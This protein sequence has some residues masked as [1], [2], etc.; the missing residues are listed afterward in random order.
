[1]RGWGMPAKTV[2]RALA[3]SAKKS[4]S[5]KA[6]QGRLRASK[7]QGKKAVGLLLSADFRLS[8]ITRIRPTNARA[9]RSGCKGRHRTIFTGT[10]ASKQ[11]SSLTCKRYLTPHQLHLRGSRALLQVVILEDVLS[12]FLLVYDIVLLTEI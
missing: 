3:A 8:R 11:G 9:S 7:N 6:I 12:I 2:R 10:G 5:K 1:M 4:T